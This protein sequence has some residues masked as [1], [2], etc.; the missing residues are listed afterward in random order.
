MLEAKLE[1]TLRDY[2]LDVEFSVNRGE[3]LIFMGRNGSGKSTTF[4]LI[5]GLLSP[6]SGAIRISGTTLFDIEQGI[7]LPVEERRIAYVFQNTA[8]FPHL[9]VNENI[10]YGLRCRATPRKSEEAIVKSWLNKMEIVEIANVRAGA[11]SGG[12]RQ[13]VALARALAIDPQILLLD[14]PFTGL[15]AGTILSVKGLI[16]E[17]VREKQIPCILVTHRISDAT[18]LGSRICLFHDGRIICTGNPDEIKTIYNTDFPECTC[19]ST[20]AP[21]N[22]KTS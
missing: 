4:N 16:R 19:I 12:Q 20:S 8:I 22:Q 6:D 15:D 7:D 21:I 18:D 9:T 14:E 10:A 17:I 2:R 5:S 13:R 3:I 1:K 11:L